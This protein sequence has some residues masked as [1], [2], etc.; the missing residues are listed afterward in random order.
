MVRPNKTIG[1]VSM[2][3]RIDGWTDGPMDGLRG[4]T[5]NGDFVLMFS[6]L[7]RGAISQRGDSCKLLFFSH[8]RSDV[9]LSI[10]SFVGTL[11][12]YCYLYVGAFCFD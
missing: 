11:R 6:I 10:R 2:R 9:L 1:C 4:A 5:A 8:F 3:R 12:I 7:V